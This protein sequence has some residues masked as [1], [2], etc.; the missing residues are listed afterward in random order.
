MFGTIDFEA[1]YLNFSLLKEILN[2]KL[3][4]SLIMYFHWD[5]GNNGNHI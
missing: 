1:K 4:G 5:N 2:N 3:F